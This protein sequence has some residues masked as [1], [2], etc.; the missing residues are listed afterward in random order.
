MRT[1][2]EV[3][4]A[5]KRQRRDTCGAAPVL[6]RALETRTRAGGAAVQN[7]THRHNECR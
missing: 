3:D 1:E 6:W 2:K 4:M 5:I 7:F